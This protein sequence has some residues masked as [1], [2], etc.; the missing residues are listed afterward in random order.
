MAKAIQ[1]VVRDSAGGTAR[2]SVAA[3]TN[4]NFIQMG[5]GDSV[6]LNLSR[7]SIASYTKQGDDLVVT[8]IDGRT[9]VLDGYFV[10]SG[11][12]NQLYL[13]Q[14]GEIVAVQLSNSG[15]GGLYASYGAVEG[16]DKY[17]NLDALRFA[18]GDDLA[19]AGGAVD[20]PAGMAMFAPGLIGLGG[21]G[22][23]AAGLGLVGLVA[24]GGGGSDGDG[25]PTG[26]VDPTGPTGPVD[27]TGPTGPV[28]PTGPT[29]PVDPT[30]PTGPVDPTGPTGPVDPTGP[31]GPVD[32]TGPTGPVDPTG[33][34]GPVDPTGPT[35]PVDPTGPT[36]PVDPTGPTGPVDPTGPTG[37]VDPTGPTGPVD[38]TGPTGPVDP[39]GPTGPVDPTGPTGPVDPTGPT[40]PVDPTGPTGPVD[41]TGPTG[42][43]D[44][45]PPT[46][47]PA[48]PKTVIIAT[49][50]KDLE[51]TGT[52]EPGDKVTVT[53][54]DKTVTTV[55]DEDGTWGVTFPG[56]N[57]PP[58]GTYEAEAVFEH[59]DG[60]TTTLPGPDFILDLTPPDVD[61][62]EGSKTVGHVENAADYTDGVRIG[63]TG[64]PGAKVKVEIE[65]HSHT[66]VI[67]ADGTWSVV[68]TT[69]EIRT[70]E[71][72]T[73]ITVTATDPLGNT[74]VIT[75]HLVVDTVPNPID[76][77]NVTRDNVVSG[78]ENTLGFA[79]TGTSVAGAVLE[80]TITAQGTTYTQTV[81]TRAD[82]T[83]TLN[84]PAGTLPAGE[85]NATIVA[86]STDAA[87]N[88]SS[89]SHTFRIDTQTSV[90]FTGKVAGDDI[91]N[92]SEATNVVLTGT[93]EPGAVVS[94]SWQGSTLPA[95]VAAN[96]TWTVVFPAVSGSAILTNTVATVTATDAY[97]NTATASRTIGIDLGNSVAFDA[98]QAGDNVIS[99]A[100]RTRG[101]TLTGTGEAG[102]T[103]VVEF[104]SGTRTVTVGTD[105]TWRASFA[106][107]EI[108]TGNGLEQ[109]AR[110]TS[111]DAA[112]NVATATHEV[113]VDT[114]VS[115][116]KVT[117]N[118]TG[119]DG[120]LNNAEAASGLTVSGTVEAG[121]QVQVT[122]GANG[123]YAATVTGTTWTVVIPAGVIPQGE[124]SVSLTA[125]ATDR[126]GN[127]GTLPAET[128]VIDRI[129]RDFTADAKIS[130][131]G[132][133]N[134]HEAASGVPF[135]GTVEPY[136]AVV[137]TLS[138][139]ETLTTRAGANGTWSVTIPG[140]YLP[141]ADGVTLTATVTATDLAG[142][143][144]TLSRDVIVD[145]VAPDALGVIGFFKGT[146]S[147]VMTELY[148][149]RD[150]EDV[151]I[152]RVDRTGGAVE[153][154]YLDVGATQVNLGGG[155]RVPANHYSLDEGV[156][157][158][159]YL[160]LQNTDAAGN[161]SSTLF[162]VDNSGN[163]NVEL[164]R[165]GLQGFDFS[166]IDLNVAPQARLTL[167]NAD[168]LALTGGDNELVIRGGQDDSVTLQLTD[169]TPTGVRE[170]DGQNYNVY[171]MD[172]GT[173]LVDQD[174]NT[175]FI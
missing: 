174:I 4:N 107:N 114:V 12:A 82:G 112:G 60:T 39:T 14:N 22:A 56:T 7:Q 100:E 80:V 69:T 118:S 143:T 127:T 142:N 92:A 52:G 15:E 25:G 163:V 111:T 148:T 53:I 50:D 21:L 122:F 64:E 41:P 168:L 37:P 137:V 29:G 94:V 6:S 106:T 27:P 28:D 19:L 83:W 90:A 16:W 59:G 156:S 47:D 170:I 42:P 129:V 11:A 72:T 67:A 49:P 34:T 164:N 117:G 35:G 99:G 146:T 173:V 89:E 165:A 87:G 95:T 172:G 133:I 2:G 126:Y 78:G 32:P 33:P 70:G 17:S 104:G 1:F 23:G 159:S 109:T 57:L 18:Q 136:A 46:V 8:L 110:V 24:G 3:D 113:N 120:V 134:A 74:T 30:G 130:G 93:A 61:I 48:D 140:S 166:S 147:N 119:A 88:S 157:D 169:T 10:T 96:G 68:F 152:Y 123:P 103:V 31:T 79:V 138:N 132:Y 71:Y 36:G 151:S 9:V 81:T 75:D 139:G 65:G 141:D 5:A 150:G 144:A 175:S 97:G 91:V 86:N 63:G 128:I 135:G 38:P 84:V 77:D 44:P 131:D 76:F 154:S 13:S 160:V 108:P 51:V 121:S 158:G 85:Y 115:P 161:E 66:T 124:T 73:G 101:V 43:V 102:A 62:T 40:G 116:F 58:D 125:V 26:P 105:G 171:V 167:T 45:R 162:I 153:Q 155:N 145:T 149:T 20:E 55:I 54:G 98:I